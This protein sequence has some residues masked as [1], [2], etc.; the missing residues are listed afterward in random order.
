MTI[1]S[2]CTEREFWK[3]RAARFR[4]HSQTLVVQFGVPVPFGHATKFPLQ[5]VIEPQLMFEGQHPP[6]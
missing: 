5:S 2:K 6:K 1:A 3:K 4:R